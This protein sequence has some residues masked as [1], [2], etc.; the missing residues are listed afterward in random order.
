MWNPGDVIA[1]RGVYNNRV[2]YI[3]SAIVVKDQPEEI[4]LAILPGA[5]CFAPEGYIDGRHGTCGRWDRWGEYEKGDWT[6]RGYA[7]RTNRLLVLLHPV[8]YYSSVY[9]WQSN[10]NEFLC[11]YINFQLPYRRSGIGFDT[12]DLEL[13]VVVEPTYEWSWKDVDEYQLGIDRG[14]ILNGWMQ[15]IDKAKPE[16]F[17][18]LA[19]R[20]YPFDGSWLDWKPDPSW[21]PPKL[22]ENWDKI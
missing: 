17:D 7:W 1:F 6:M 10:T 9:F 3:Q 22:P 11:Y 12:F 20:Q 14:V 16:I 19:R 15:E 4:A 2:S 8:K 21:I 5:E 13:D 18:K